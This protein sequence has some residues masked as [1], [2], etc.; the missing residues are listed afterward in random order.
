MPVG[1]VECFPALRKIPHERR[2]P[3][4]DRGNGTGFSRHRARRASGRR[5]G[6]KAVVNHGRVHLAPAGFAAQRQEEAFGEDF[7]PSAVE[8]V[9]GM[10]SEADDFGAAQAAGEADK[11]DGA[12][13]EPAQTPVGGVGSLGVSEAEALA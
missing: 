1:A 9:L 13:P 8:R 4:L 3:T 10:T 5:N 7:N 2:Q 12:V 11:Q 6:H